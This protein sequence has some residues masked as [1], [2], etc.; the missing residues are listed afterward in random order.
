MT[1]LKCV[2]INVI[3]AACKS[4]RGIG[5]DNDLPWK[6]PTDMKYFREKTASTTEIRVGVIMGRRTWESVPPKFRPFK[7]RF[8]VVLTSREDFEAKGAVI[9]RTLEDA[10]K[11]CSNNVDS[12]WVIGGSG[13][14]AEALNKY[15]CRVYLTEIDKEFDCDAF[16]PPLDEKKYKLASVSPDH[17]ENDITFRFKVYDVIEL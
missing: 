6:L 17:Q 12:I 8:N 10:V 7:N 9:A 13:V 1:S 14:Y 15:P 16:F 3:A 11:K 2:K 4:S 5:K